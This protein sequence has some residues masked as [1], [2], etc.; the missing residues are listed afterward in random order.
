MTSAKRKLSYGFHDEDSLIAMEE[1]IGIPIDEAELQR[2][3]G[4]ETMVTKYLLFKHAWKIL[5]QLYMAASAKKMLMTMGALGTS[6][7]MSKFLVLLRNRTEFTKKTI[8]GNCIGEFKYL[9]R[10]WNTFHRKIDSHNREI[11]TNSVMNKMVKKHHFREKCSKFFGNLQI[12]RH[13]KDAIIS[14]ILYST[15][16]MLK[17]AMLNLKTNAWCHSKSSGGN[18]VGGCSQLKRSKILRDNYMLQNF[19][20]SWK[21]SAHHGRLTAYIEKNSHYH[22]CRQ[23]L[24]R[25]MRHLKLLTV[26][27]KSLELQLETFHGTVIRDMLLRRSLHCMRSRVEIYCLQ[28]DEEDYAGHKH[29]KYIVYR[30]FC[31]WSASYRNRFSDS[32]RLAMSCSYVRSRSKKHLLAL[33]LDRRRELILYRAFTT[34]AA[35]RQKKKM[36]S[37]FFAKWR[38]IRNFNTVVTIVSK[39]QGAKLGKRISESTYRKSPRMIEYGEG[40]QQI[41]T[42]TIPRHVLVLFKYWSALCNALRVRKAYALKLSA[43]T[44]Y[45]LRNICKISFGAFLLIHEEH[46]SMLYRAERHIA[47]RSQ[48]S[49]FHRLER[50]TCKTF[51]SRERQRYLTMC[52][53]DLKLR[54]AFRCLLA[55]TRARRWEGE[56]SASLVSPTDHLSLPVAS[57]EGGAGKPAV[58]VGNAVI[59]LGAKSSSLWTSRQMHGTHDE[60]RTTH[61]LKKAI[62]ALRKFKDIGRSYNAVR[63]IRIRRYATILITQW[64]GSKAARCLLNACYNVVTANTLRY[65][66]TQWVVDCQ[67][68]NDVLKL[69]V[70]KEKEKVSKHFRLWMAYISKTHMDR[71][72]FR[73]QFGAYEGKVLLRKHFHSFVTQLK[74]WGPV[75]R[76]AEAALT[77]GNTVM[78]RK[79]VR[80]WR[81]QTQKSVVVNERGGRNRDNGVRKLKKSWETAAARRGRGILVAQCRVR[82]LKSWVVRCFLDYTQDRAQLHRSKRALDSYVCD[83]LFRDA[84]SALR[85][86]L[87]KRHRSEKITAVYEKTSRSSALSRAV[88]H[89]DRYCVSRWVASQKIRR[90]VLHSRNMILKRGFRQLLL[91]TK[92]KK[93][94]LN[95]TV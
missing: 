82:Y 36:L 90:A 69:S 40:S 84:F 95:S 17:K 27:A 56:G 22:C 80:K 35:D 15:L 18:R 75:S 57:F 52:I 6:K 4:Y 60:N 30:A 16:R 54:R 24:L 19:L 47:L 44:E 89:I 65:Y 50:F 88:S 61:M 77:V 20:L 86:V 63:L 32:D 94:F 5:R 25:G 70:K 74:Q 64:K 23:R 34:F 37:K 2:I 87:R 12:R 1:V 48:Y 13:F 14:A 8:L 31:V 7:S 11:K 49:A 72:L 46:L 92:R 39:L 79:V 33:W 41:R 38:T 81:L 73:P 91:G 43:A 62:L 67:I 26:C 66:F 78:M 55:L 85:G 53:A 10:S 42:R 58:A 28:K 51:E 9:R 93:C 83:R 21:A 76:R 59:R 29:L 3:K 71:L 68:N 45:R